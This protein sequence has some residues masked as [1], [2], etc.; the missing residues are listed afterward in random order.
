MKIQ[1]LGG[2]CSNCQKLEA[3]AR[4][5]LENLGISAEI[6]KIT[7]FDT[8]ADMGVLITPALA[9]DNDVKATGK[10]LSP[11]QIADIIKSL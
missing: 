5:A 6:E 3:N 10:V 4:A 1:I 11:E 9:I 7:D 2:G 8:I